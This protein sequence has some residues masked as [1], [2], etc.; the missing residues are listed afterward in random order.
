MATIAD[1]ILMFLQA[2]RMIGEKCSFRLIKLT[3]ADGIR[4]VS[5]PM[6]GS[7]SLLSESAST[8]GEFD[9]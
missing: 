9:L 2:V 5:L 8:W 3:L 4:I 7:Y 6:L 1:W